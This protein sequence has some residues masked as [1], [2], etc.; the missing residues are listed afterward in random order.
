MKEILLAIVAIVLL[1]VMVFL[2]AIVYV[3]VALWASRDPDGF[4]DD[5]YI[6]DDEK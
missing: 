5:I 2:G 1:V 4:D 6:E 3:A